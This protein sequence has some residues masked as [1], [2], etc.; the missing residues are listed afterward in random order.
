MK[1]QSLNLAY[2]VKLQI[3]DAVFYK[4]KKSKIGLLSQLALGKEKRNLKAVHENDGTFK[5]THEN[6]SFRAVLEKGKGKNKDRYQIKG[7]V[8]STIGDYKERYQDVK[9]GGVGESG[10]KLRPAQIGAVYALLSHWSVSDDVSTIVLPTGTGKTETMLVTTLADKAQRT[11]VVVP[12]VELKLQIAE[13][14]ESWGILR[15]LGVIPQTFPN[16]TIIVLN[17]TLTEDN[18]VDFLKTADVIVTTPALI[19]QAPKEIKQSLKEIFSHVYFDEAHH[20]KANEWEE[21]KTLLD[22]AKIVQFTATPYRNDRKPIEGKIVYN[23]PLS[24]ALEDKC[25]SKISLVTVDEL[26]PKKKDKAIAETAME[27]LQEDRKKGWKN[28]CMMVR[29]EKEVHAEKLFKDY[30]KWYPDEKIIIIHSNIKGKKQIIE[31]IKKREFDIIVCVDM[32]KEGFDFPEFKIAAVHGVHKSLSVLLQFIGRFTRPKKGLGDASFVVNYAEEKMSIELENLFQ[33]GSGWEKV[34]SEIADAKK[35][36]AE[37]LLT[38]LQGCKPYSG[39]DSPDIELNPKL[40]YPALSC[41]A[42]QCKKVD[43]KLFKNAFNLNKYALSQP[44]INSEENIFYFTTQKRDKVKWARTNA[45]KD[46]TWD[47][48]V[49][50]HDPKTEI[51]YIGYSEKRLDLNLLVEKI[52]RKKPIILNGDCVFRS[53]DSIKR[54]SIVHAGIFKPANQLHRYSRLSGAD[55][56]TELSRWQEGKRSKKSDFVGIGFRDGLPVSVGAS[57]KGKLWSPARIGN[58][59]E[60]KSWCLNI[61]RLITDETI[62]SNQLLVD[63]AKKV[64]LEEFPEDINVLATDWAEELYRRIHKLTIQKHN[65]N[66]YLLSECSLTTIKYESNRADFKLNLFSD[67]ILFYILLGGENGFTVHGLDDSKFNVEGLKREPLPLKK[68]FEEN[69]PTM[70]LLNGCTIAGCIHTDYGSPEFG[71]IPDDRVEALKW[72]NVKYTVESLYKEGIKR[73]NSIQEYM[74][75]SLIERGADIVFNDDNS[76]EKADII[77][78]FSS[79]DLIRFELIHCKYSKQ[80]SGARKSDLYEVCGQAIVSLRYKWKPEELLKHMERRNGMGVLKGLRFFH[81]DLKELDKIKKELKYK[82]VAFEFAI[83]QPGVEKSNLTVD[84][85]NFLGSVFSTIIEMTETKLRCYF[86]E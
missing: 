55:V 65:S 86:N 46:Q 14:F 78:I 21:I 2:E 53:F 58:L 15:E 9:I 83:A 25:F 54:L 81:G 70:F 48:I 38:F 8:E 39:F 33:E 52:T 84:M 27:R 19:A 11:L 61:G 51:L 60:W 73:E 67:E 66:S 10:I 29:A 32:L 79:E 68:F 82:E 49:M 69:P 77:G 23:Y 59:K 22:K 43:W 34:I 45:L 3:E 72:E 57:V 41:V 85:N 12:T 1:Q 37:S 20:V 50:H 30:K 62:D 76:G 18:S 24:K 64:Q 35:A 40:V 36:E 74:M 5:I 75:K 47:L 17:K 63:S 7:C 16:P 56:T 44:Y 71:K 26:H 4:Y 28:H 42:Y 80:K 13:K 31:R 6:I